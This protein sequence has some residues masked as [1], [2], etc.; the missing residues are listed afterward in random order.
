MQTKITGSGLYD[1]IVAQVDPTHRALRTSLRPNETGVYGSY[2]LSMRSGVI[3]AGITANLPVWEFRWGSSGA[4]AIIRKLK[5]QAIA[6]TTAFAATAA[7]S[8]FSLY[9]AQGFT[10]LDTTGATVAAFTKGKAQTS[11][12][13]MAS[14]LLAGD[15]TATRT[16]AGGIAISNTAAMSGGTKILDDNPIAVVL[17]RILA[18]AAAETIISPEFD[19]YLIDPSEA[20]AVPPI[21]LN[22]S[23]GLVL[24]ADA[25]TATGTW[26]LKVDVAWDEIDPARYFAL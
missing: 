11:A 25:I 10:A 17:N 15:T 22:L 21:E 23:E 12:T 6:S 19:P 2:R 14:T 8:S 13:R 5:M 18:S 7:D 9:R 20:A 26:R 24:Q 4:I 3:G 16:G 1:A